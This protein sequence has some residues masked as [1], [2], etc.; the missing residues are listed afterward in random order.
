MCCRYCME[1][2]RRFEMYLFKLLE[3]LRHIAST[4]YLQIPEQMFARWGL[5]RSTLR[6]KTFVD[7]T[8]QNSLLGRVVLLFAASMPKCKLFK[9]MCFG[10]SRVGSQIDAHTPRWVVGWV[11]AENLIQPSGLFTSL[12]IISASRALPLD[13]CVGY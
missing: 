12:Q 11:P 4:N 13:V 2:R 5:F 10:M 8:F 3:T 7:V 1:C 6:N 9:R